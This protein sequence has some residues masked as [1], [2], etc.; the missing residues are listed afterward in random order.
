MTRLRPLIAIVAAAVVLGGCI[1]P[2]S[3]PASA[4][5]A[6]TPAPAVASSTQDGLVLTFTIDPVAV[7]V[8]EVV[9][10]GV[11]LSNDGAGPIRYIRTACGLPATVELSLTDPKE[12]IGRTWDGITGTFKD[13]A[14]T[15][16]SA[17]GAP[18]ALS[19][20]SVQFGAVCDGDPSIEVL[21]P[22]KAISGAISGQIEFGDGVPA[23]PG[24]VQLVATA[25]YTTAPP[26]EQP[27]TGGALGQSSVAMTSVLAE[28]VVSLT[29]SDRPVSA[30]QALDAVLANEQFSGWLQ[31][32]PASTWSGANIWLDGAGWHVELF[33]EIGVQ[34]NFALAYIDPSTGQVSKVD[35]CRAPCKR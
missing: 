19:P 20:R 13:Y 18:V 8:G 10:A 12:P 15:K 17:P 25:I 4:A 6:D 3:L 28:G 21:E 31:E 30:G 22:G 2:S 35:I 16:A 26:A 27:P 32:Q 33:R 9:A 24:P 14:L 34:R 29:G 5:A 7:Q 23:P 1:R 11:S